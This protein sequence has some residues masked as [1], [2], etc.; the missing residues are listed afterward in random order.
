MIYRGV[1]VPT[2]KVKGKLLLDFVYV[3]FSDIYYPAKDKK[4]EEVYRG[5]GVVFPSSDTGLAIN[6]A[7]NLVHFLDVE[8]KEGEGSGALF[9]KVVKNNI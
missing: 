1:E 6:M 5:A 7:R 4:V 8:A 9:Y 2:V 3:D